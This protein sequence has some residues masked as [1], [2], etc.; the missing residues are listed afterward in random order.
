MMVIDMIKYPVILFTDENVF[1]YPNVQHLTVANTS[2]LKQ[3]RY[4]NALLVDSEYNTYLIKKAKKIKKLW[5]T[6]L[7][8]D[9][10]LKSK[11]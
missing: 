9:K 1:V 8:Q 11:Y 10:S 7:V 6:T 3:E 2:E 5:K 4:K